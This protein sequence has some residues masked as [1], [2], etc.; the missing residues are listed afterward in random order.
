MIVKVRDGMILDGGRV[1]RRAAIVVVV[2]VAIAKFTPFHGRVRGNH[3]SDTTTT[4]NAL[5]YYKFVLW[6][7]TMAVTVKRCNMKKAPRGEETVTK[8]L[9]ASSVWGNQEQLQRGTG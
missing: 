6:K 3:H 1:T 9:L 4:S 5:D 8:F 2:I 7:R